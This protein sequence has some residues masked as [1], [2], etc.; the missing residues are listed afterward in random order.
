MDALY[1]Q[2]NRLVQEI[3]GQDL[4][5]L[6]RVGDDM[7]REGVEGEIEQKLEAVKR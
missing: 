5:R 3:Q 7:S 6:E 2:T 1:H 4:V